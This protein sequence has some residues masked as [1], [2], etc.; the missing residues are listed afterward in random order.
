MKTDYFI[1][2]DD[3]GNIID[4]WPEEETDSGQFRFQ[5]ELKDDW[6]GLTWAYNL[7]SKWSVGITNF[8]SV[9]HQNELL[10]TEVQAYSSIDEL[11]ILHNI[12]RLVHNEN[13]QMEVCTWIQHTIF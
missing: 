8:V 6:F 2:N 1:H 12:R 10:A 9:R 11:A 13:W 7:N 3:V 4:A 5:K